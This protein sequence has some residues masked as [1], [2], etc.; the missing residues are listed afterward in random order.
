MDALRIDPNNETP[1]IIF[2]PVNHQYE[3]SGVSLP[4]DARG[5]YDPIIQWWK[6]YANVISES[7][8][9]DVRM[10][11]FNTAS[12]KCFLDL[13]EQM[14]KMVK[15]GADIKVKWYY[16]E[17]DDDMHSAGEVFNDL[18]DIDFEFIEEEDDDDDFDDF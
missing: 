10:I 1:T 2:D 8:V 11:Y 16:A 17:G 6:D 7:I 4:E 15:N 18:V 3:L 5:Y 12:S 14:N 9:I 13:F